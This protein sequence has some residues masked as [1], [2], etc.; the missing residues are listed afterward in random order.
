MMATSEPNEAPQ[1]VDKEG[2]NALLVSDNMRVSDKKVKLR[3]K[4]G[5]FSNL[6]K[7]KQSKT[8]EQSSSL[9]HVSTTAITDDVS[10]D[11]GPQDS[12][13]YLRDRV[14]SFTVKREGVDRVETEEIEFVA[15]DDAANQHATADVPSSQ[16]TGGIPAEENS[17]D[18]MP[19]GTHIMNSAPTP[20]NELM[21]D[22]ISET[23]SSHT[24][25]TKIVHAENASKHQTNLP[26][27]SHSLNKTESKFFS[28]IGPC[29]ACD[30]ISDEDT[31]TFCDD[32]TLNTLSDDTR[33]F[34]PYSLRTFTND[35]ITL[36]STNYGDGSLNTLSA[37][38]DEST[39]HDVVEG[40]LASPVNEGLTDSPLETDVVTKRLSCMDPGLLDWMNCSQEASD[41]DLPE[42]NLN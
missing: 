37:A 24:L 29:Q 2:R 39:A 26:R 15:V 7:R 13:D 41:L 28:L 23:S 20:T 16:P 25:P 34:T 4:F 14:E 9:S 19:E 42:L 22:S 38:S 8:S 35:D 40:F 3:R 27:E 32:C 36:A 21:I 6:L 11:G 18:A 33:C 1:A 30:D 5:I 12:K 31:R 17:A 10:A